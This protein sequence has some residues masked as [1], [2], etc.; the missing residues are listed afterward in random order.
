MTVR[1][2]CFALC[3]A[4]SLAQCLPAT[5]GEPV[6][7]ELDYQFERKSPAYFGDRH[8]MYEYAEDVP[9]YQTVAGCSTSDGVYR[10]DEGEGGA[11][12]Y[13]LCQNSRYTFGRGHDGYLYRSPDGLNWERLAAQRPWLMY[14]L[15]DDSLLG[16]WI[17]S[18]HRTTVDRSIDD[19]L[20][21]EAAKWADT[22]T[23]FA[24]LTTGAWFYSTGWGFHQADNGTIVMVEYKLP[25]GGR[26]IY[27]SGDGGATWRV[28]HDNGGVVKHY[29]AVTKHK[30]LNRWVAVIGDGIMAQ[31]LVVSDDDAHTWY[32]YTFAGERNLQPTYLLDYGHPTRL[33]FGSDS[34]WQVGWLDVSD[35]PDAKKM[36]SLITN[37]GPRPAKNYCCNIFEHNGVYYA[38]N[39]DT[40]TPRNPV[41]S[42]SE[43]L[44]HWAVYHRFVRAEYGNFDCAGAAGGKL[45]LKPRTAAE[46]YE[47]LVISPTKVKLWN[48][49][50]LAPPTENLF[51]AVASSAASVEGW[52]NRSEEIPPGSGQR[53]L[54]E[55]VD[56]TAHHGDSCLHYVR[57]DGGYMMLD[58]PPIPFEIGKTYQARYWVK[59]LAHTLRTYWR[60]NGHGEGIAIQVGLPQDEWREVIMAPFTVPADAYELRLELWVTSTSGNLC[61][62]YLDSLQVEE[63]PSTH[64]HLGGTARAPT[65]VTAAVPVD[66]A[67]TNVFTI[68]PGNLSEYLEKAGELHVRTYEWTPNTHVDLYLD[69]EQGRF[70]LQATVGGIPQ[71]PIAT[72]PQYFI[73][74]AQI[75]FAVGS[76]DEQLTL[77]ISNGQPVEAITTT[78]EGLPSSGDLTIRCYDVLG[79]RKLLPCTVFDDTIFHSQTPQE[80]PVP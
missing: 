21:W 5:A 50:V 27:R 38:C 14:A 1:I 12:I 6:R 26:Y 36:A 72:S 30:G 54:L 59:G 45:H 63:V 7:S 22:G 75:R 74:R 80:R 61:E 73:R 3:A 20:T 29:H 44:Q 39:W 58:S 57:S 35:G 34:D 43:D 64:W 62:V 8:G 25:W 28:V 33:L 15:S 17:R 47:H 13:P 40:R 60:R 41:I 52:L 53:G 18:D 10:Y 79:R 66:G 76:A 31:K 16:V 65:R 19:G 49:L 11:D 46:N 67:W 70:K 32:D 51:D 78:C 48:G 56:Y 9:I 2:R 37:W 23:D 68:Q 77:A 71:D 42:V 69:A 55:C 24:W 4:C